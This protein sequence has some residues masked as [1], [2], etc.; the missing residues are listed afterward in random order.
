LVAG[1][2][3]RRP[4]RTVVFSGGGMAWEDL[5]IAALYRRH[6]ARTV[7]CTDAPA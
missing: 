2:L 7:D 5:V 4:G 6:L 3:R 1:R